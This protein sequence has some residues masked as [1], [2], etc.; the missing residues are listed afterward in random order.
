MYNG[1]RTSADQLEE[2][3]GTRVS[4]PISLPEAENDQ[5][6]ALHCLLQ[7][8]GRARLVGKGG[9]PAVELP[10]AVFDLLM[11]II[12]GLQQRKSHFNC[13]HHS[14]PNDPAGSGDAGRIPA[15]LRKAA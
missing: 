12:E 10:D 14:G 11:K 1:V 4:D 5:V 13:A 15:V 9:E 2:A 7:K 6:R 8:E 3:M